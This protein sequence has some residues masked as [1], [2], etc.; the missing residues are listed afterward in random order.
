MGAY[1]SSQKF[2][3]S[4]SIGKKQIIRERPQ[5][6]KIDMMGI[7]FRS[8]LLIYTKEVCQEIITRLLLGMTITLTSSI[9]FPNVVS[10]PIHRCG[11]FYS[12]MYSLRWWLLIYLGVIANVTRSTF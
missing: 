5:D 11:F 2:S 1:G 12:L 7:N 8:S 4:P 9:T 6:S 3:F 10:Q